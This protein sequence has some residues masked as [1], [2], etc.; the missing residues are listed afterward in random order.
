MRLIL[1]LKMIWKK[2][3]KYW[4]RMSEVFKNIPGVGGKIISFPLIV[5]LVTPFHY[6]FALMHAFFEF[7]LMFCNKKQ[8]DKNME[9]HF[10]MVA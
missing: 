6:A 5:I 7:C 8:F 1:L 3:I 9:T 10:K 4:K 2:E